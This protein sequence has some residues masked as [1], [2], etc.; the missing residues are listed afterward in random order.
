MKGKFYILANSKTP[1][2]F[3]SLGQAL[4]YANAHNTKVLRKVCQL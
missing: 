2:W 4:I 1:Q 3:I